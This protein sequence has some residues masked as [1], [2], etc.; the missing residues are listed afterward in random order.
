MPKVYEFRV[1]K[2]SRK[3]SKDNINALL[4]SG[5]SN[6]FYLCGL[7]IDNCFLLISDSNKCFIFTD[8]RFENELSNLKYKFKVIIENSSI[9][10]RIDQICQKEKI[11]KLAIEANSLNLDSFNKLSKSL[12][13]VKILPKSNI[14]QDL[15]LIKQP[16]EI[17]KIKKS[18]SILSK[19]YKK[20]DDFIDKS[21]TE[22][23]L[24]YRLEY[25][26]KSNFKACFSFDPIIASG[27]NSCYPHAKLSSNL[28]LKSEYILVDIGVRFKGY[29]CDLTRI[30]VLSKMRPRQQKVYDLLLTHQKELLSLIK[31]GIELSEVDKFS[32]SRLSK[33]GFA[34]NIMHSVGHGIGIDVHENPRISFN[35]KHIAKPGM[36]LTIEP[37]LYFPDKWGMR[38]EDMVLV[39]DSGN[40][41]LTKSI[42]K[43][44]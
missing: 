30:Y 40:Q 27:K 38:I 17:E 1:K 35:N 15:R 10:K 36:V 14:I 8:S 20:I 23:E 44:I 11:K 21:L 26:L 24:A 32:R 18:I 29:S 37:G 7:E 19:L 3:I 12:D 6:I 2:L 33:A 43:K 4:V 28:I 9:F 5:T 25:Y 16:C 22:Q 42:S 31:P 13:S 34:K 39:T 41:V